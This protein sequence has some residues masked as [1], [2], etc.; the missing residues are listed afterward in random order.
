MDVPV[1]EQ[2]P[3]IVGNLDDNAD[4]GIP[5]AAEP[6]EPE[7]D[8]DPEP[9]EAGEDGDAVPE[10]FATKADFDRFVT[11]WKA[12]QQGAAPGN[13]P[14]EIDTGDDYGEFLKQEDVPDT[15]TASQRP[16][17]A[18]ETEIREALWKFANEDELVRHQT[19]R[20]FL[21]K[22]SGEISEA[23]WA[24]YVDLVVA[25][26]RREF[27]EKQQTL[28]DKGE[29]RIEATVVP[30]LKAN[31]IKGADV[32]AVA[33]KV[34]RVVGIDIRNPVSVAQ[35]PR[36]K[37]REALEDAIIV[38]KAKRG[39]N[40]KTST[41]TAPVSKPPKVA[42]AGG[43]KSPVSPSKPDSSYDGDFRRITEDAKAGR[44]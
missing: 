6:S 41:P 28:A 29:E 3:I 25:R 42:P 23:D 39:T 4:G 11:E 2:E 27:T 30:L 12:K 34:L 24:G 14:A 20:L 22:E 15:A 9:N 8:K 10:S 44:I 33:D 18:S 37:L 16:P 7:G 13:E 1:Q 26:G 19:N 43:G 17:Q 5:P 31:G 35:A 38:I 36:G 32:K 40:G 21:Q